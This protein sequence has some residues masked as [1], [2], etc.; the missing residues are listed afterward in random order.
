MVHASSKPADEPDMHARFA[1]LLQT[2]RR[3]ILH[4]ARL[5]AGHAD[6]RADLAQEIC[7][8][9]WRAFPGYDAARTFSTWAYRIALNVGISHLRQHMAHRER[10]A[11]WSDEIADRVAD[12]TPGPGALDPL[13]ELEVLVAALAPLERALVGLY[14]DD[15]SYAEI[16][17]VLGLTETNVAT[18]LNRLKA[19]WRDQSRTERHS[20]AHP[21]APHKASHGDAHGT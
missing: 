1:A 13:R 8:Q 6:D 12:P 2:H 5:Y 3:I 4:V 19:R 20:S 10:F 7:V 15:L 16:A 11:P 18:K 21:L 17:D 9:L 14:L